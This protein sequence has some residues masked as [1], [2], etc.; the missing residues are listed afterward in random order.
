MR[1]LS[2]PWCWPTETLTHERAMVA[3]QVAA[4]NVE[5]GRVPSEDNEADLG[6]KHLERDCIKKCVT[7]MGM[8]FAGAWAGEPV[9]CGF[10]HCG[11]HWRGPD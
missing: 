10:G 7:K 11:D 3:D 2:T 9:A 6:T 1:H 5:L 4:K 8:L